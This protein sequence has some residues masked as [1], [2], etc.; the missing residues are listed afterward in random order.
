M[1]DIKDSEIIFDLANFIVQALHVNKCNEKK[2]DWNALS[3]LIENYYP[4]EINE[5]IFSETLSLLNS[6]ITENQTIH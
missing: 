1:N 5:E 2:I 3:I 6:I 4:H